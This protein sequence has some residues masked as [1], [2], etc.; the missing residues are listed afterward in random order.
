MSKKL[1]FWSIWTVFT[2]FIVVFFFALGELKQVDFGK[3]LILTS[4]SL[5]AAIPIYLWVKKNNEFN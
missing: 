4:I 1:A 2:L 3:A 5:I